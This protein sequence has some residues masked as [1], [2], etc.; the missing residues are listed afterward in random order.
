MDCT[1][2]ANVS[3]ILMGGFDVV[4]PFGE[5]CAGD[6]VRVRNWDELCEI[7]RRSGVSI[8]PPDEMG[9]FAF[10]E[11]MKYMCDKRYMVK[12]VADSL[13]EN[14]IVELF[15]E[16][17]PQESFVVEEWMVEL[18]SRSAEIETNSEES[19]KEFLFG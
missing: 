15:F 9:N 13:Y 1:Q 18:V 11:D 16:D 6:V 3:F 14:G 12:G 4:I 17:D 19:L 5:V 10:V 2:Q 7:G 8:A